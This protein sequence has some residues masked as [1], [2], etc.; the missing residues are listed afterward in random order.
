MTELLF[1]R[2]TVGNSVCRAH[3]QMGMLSLLVAAGAASPEIGPG[4]KTRL[5]RPV[6]PLYR[7]GRNEPCPCGSGKKFKK[8]CRGKAAY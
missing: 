2:Q 7:A 6:Q 8:C 3:T 4:R 1:S 5:Q